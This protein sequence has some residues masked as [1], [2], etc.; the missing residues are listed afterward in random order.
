MGFRLMRLR[1]LLPVALLL[2]VAACATPFEARVARF[3]SLPAP[4]GQTFTVAAVDPAKAGGLQFATYAGILRQR[5]IAAGY[6]EATDPRSAALVAEFDYGVSMPREKI[7]TR[8]GFGGGFGYGGLGY[9]GFGYGGFGYHGYGGFGYGFPRYGYG[10]YDPFYGPE[11]YSVTRFNAFADVR[12]NRAADHVAVFEGRAE[13]VAG[14]NNLTV[15]VP[16]LVSALFTNFPG[17]SGE[18]VRVRI[19]PQHPDTPVM[20]TGPR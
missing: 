9:G 20:S 14:T 16:N 3:Q 8:P 4:A 12:I 11:V 2:G 1:S 19:D 13:T 5:M 17:R 7:E 18:T 6:A 10:F 15:L